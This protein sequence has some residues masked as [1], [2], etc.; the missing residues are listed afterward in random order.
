M[1]APNSNNTISGEFRE[2]NDASK[3][4]TMVAQHQ[5]YKPKTY[6]TAE[7]WLYSIDD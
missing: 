3:W 1:A 2:L 6:N 5:C 7:V 4:L